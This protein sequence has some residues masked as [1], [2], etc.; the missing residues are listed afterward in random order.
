MPDWA[1]YW[2]VDSCIECLPYANSN[3][4]QLVQRDLLAA[5]PQAYD[6]GPERWLGDIWD[7]LNPATQR[8]ICEAYNK[9]HRA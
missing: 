2:P 9:E 1:P 6:D 3:E 4:S 7:K 8:M 5:C